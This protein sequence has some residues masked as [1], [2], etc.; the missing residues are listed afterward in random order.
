MTST[1][2]ALISH[3]HHRQGDGERGLHGIEKSV[4][5][6]RG[7][8]A[9]AAPAQ[10]AERQARRNEVGEDGPV[11][12]SHPRPGHRE[13]GRIF[14]RQFSDP[15]PHHGAVSWILGVGTPLRPHDSLLEW[16]AR[17]LGQ[18]LPVQ[19]S[20]NVRGAHWL[21]LLVNINNAL[22]AA[23]NLTMGDV[24]ADRD[25][26]HLAVLMMREGIDTLRQAA[27]AL[28]SI[29]D[30][31]TGMVLAVRWMPV[32]IAG[33]ITALRVRRLQTRWPVLG[34]TLQSLRRGRPTEND[35]LNGEIVRLG[36]KLS[37][38]TPINE[39]LVAMV[40][41]SNN[42]RVSIPPTIFE[43]CSAM[44]ADG[45]GRNSPPPPHE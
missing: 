19:M 38:P 7:D 13:R 31:S 36:R 25:L 14:A 12:R 4:R 15:R 27:I 45:I 28:E 22:P 44:L 26:R 32:A 5:D 41:D 34:S 23:T 9:A 20:D 6:R 8:G 17:I 18:A 3:K 1:I 42:R 33:Y 40:H 21:K 30:V 35:F 16:V 10:P 2:T 39:R 37:F 43:R 11:C 29:P 24:Y